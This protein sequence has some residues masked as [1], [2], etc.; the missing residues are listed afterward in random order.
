[1]TFGGLLRQ[2][3]SKQGLGIKRLAPHL[4]VSYSYL[5]KLE[6]EEVSP[7]EALVERIAAY[8]RYD[9]DQLLLVAGRVPPEILRILQENPEDAVELLREHFGRRSKRGP[10]S[11]SVPTD[12]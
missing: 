1:M 6:N 2:L 3:R 12:S 7:S 5:S 9:R 11:R 4:G 10:K 8:F